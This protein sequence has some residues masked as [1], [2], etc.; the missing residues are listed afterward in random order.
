MHAGSRETLLG[1]GPGVPL[2]KQCINAT[3]GSV[4]DWAGARGVFNPSG[5]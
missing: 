4:Q 3:S 1:R 2:R 5:L